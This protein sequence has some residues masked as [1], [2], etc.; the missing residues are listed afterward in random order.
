MV[1]KADFT[2][3]EWK[4]ILIAPQMASIYISLS[5]PGG[6]FGTI[7]EMMVYSRLIA[8]AEITAGGNALVSAVAE[9]VKGMIERKEKLEMPEMSRNLEEIKTQCIKTFRRLDILLK[10]KAPDDA[11]GYKRWVYK[12]A[13]NSAEAAREGGFLGFGGVMVNEAEADALKEIAGALYIAV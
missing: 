4:D 10:E 13:K 2:A 5:S 7:K 1:K 12:A 11:D 3:E 6:L 8:E 9:D